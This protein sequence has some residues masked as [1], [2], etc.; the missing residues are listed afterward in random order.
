MISM[1]RDILDDLLRW[2]ADPDHKPAMIRGVRQCG[3]T[4]A[5]KELGRHYPDCAYF[6][7]EEQRIG[8]LF[9]QDYSVD[10]IVRLLGALR[11]RSIG[12]DCLIILDEIQLCSAA[13]TALK[14]FCEDGRY[15]VI[16]AGSLLGV[17]LMTTSPPVGKVDDFTMYPMSFREFL[18]ANGQKMVVDT[19][20]DD[21][22]PSA[23][24]VFADRLIPLYREYLAVGGLPE[25]VGSWA[26][27]HDSSAVDSIL[28]SL[29]DRY[30]LD[31]VRYGD[32]KVKSNGELVWRS[33]PSQL[34][35]D[36]NRFVMGHVSEG[37]RARDLW[38]SVDWLDM[39]GL[40]HAVPITVG[41]GSVPSVQSDLSAFKLYCFDTGVMRVLADI[42]FSDALIDSDRSSL[43]RGAIAENYV[44][45]ELLRMTAHRIWCWRSGNRAEVDFLTRFDSGPVPIEVKAGEKV[46]ANSLKVYLDSHEGMGVVAS[47]NPLAKK[48][49]VLM[50]PL[51]AF[52]LLPSI[53]K[54]S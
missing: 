33:I 39:A 41:T 52:W 34:A 10:R 25:A 2:K 13:I 1:E 51:Y 22:S 16:C 15:D 40:A 19:M 11:G 27:R 20:E 49:R 8:D 28:R 29:A 6:N 5:M 38:S 42:P 23:V 53:L 7:F 4:W 32:F 44:L 46:R 9:E 14:Y 21:P 17:K 48:D 24:E 43:Y 26:D 50:V 54:K 37:V 18:V 36:N 47:M 45:C 35:K 3:K 31:I 12:T 30:V